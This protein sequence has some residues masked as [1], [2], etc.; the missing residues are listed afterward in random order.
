MLRVFADARR[1]MDRMDGVTI[2]TITLARNPQEERTIP[3]ALAE[4]KGFSIITAD[5]GSRPRFIAALHKLGLQIICPRQ[6]GLV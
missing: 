6:K 5:G 4:L 3:E 2:A 1:T